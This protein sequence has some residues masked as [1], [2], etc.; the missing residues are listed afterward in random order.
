[1]TF[2]AAWMNYDD[3]MHFEGVR[4]WAIGLVVSIAAVAGIAKITGLGQKLFVLMMSTAALLSGLTS[5]IVVFLLWMAPED[6][7]AMADI[8]LSMEEVTLEGHD[9]IALALL[10]AVIILGLAPAVIFGER[11]LPLFVALVAGAWGILSVIVFVMAI[12]GLH[13]EE[14]GAGTP[15]PAAAPAESHLILE[16]DEEAPTPDLRLRPPT[17]SAYYG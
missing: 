10:M 8:P 3:E 6:G 15:A 16:V 2:I 14:E 11:I 12:F 1:M 5:L 4:W 13:E 17:L 7:M 9:S